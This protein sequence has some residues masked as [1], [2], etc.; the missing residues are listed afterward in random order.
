MKLIVVIFNFLVEF[1]LLAVPRMVGLSPITFP[2]DDRMLDLGPITFSS[3]LKIL[4]LSQT[5][6]SCELKI[7]DLSQAT[8]ANGLIGGRFSTNVALVDDFMLIRLLGCVAGAYSASWLNTPL[9]T[10][11]L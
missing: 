4:A 7:L 5:T 11:S 2:R 3:G 9:L 6:F 10:P 8:L 1:Q